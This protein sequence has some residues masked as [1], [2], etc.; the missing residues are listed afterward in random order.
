MDEKNNGARRRKA[1][2]DFKENQY[3][4]SFALN[5]TQKRNKTIKKVL[6]VSFIIIITVLFI[7]IG[8]CFTDSL[9]NISEEPYKDTNTYTAKYV[10]TSTTTTQSTEAST[11]EEQSSVYQENSVYQE[12]TASTQSSAQ[13]PYQY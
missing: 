13:T 9:L 3:D 5:P 7:I 1:F 4:N 12:S 10:N 11:E 2:A 8:F 6:T